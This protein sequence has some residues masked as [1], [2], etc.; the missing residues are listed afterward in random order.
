MVLSCWSTTILEDVASSSGGLKWFQI[1][2]LRRQDVMAKLIKRA[3]SA[4]Y[5]A[6]VLTLDMPVVGKRYKNFRFTFTVPPHPN[7]KEALQSENISMVSPD[8]ENSLHDPS[9]TWDTLIPW[10]KSIT[11]LRV[12]LKG[13]LTIEDA[14]MAV[15]HGVDGI[16]VSNHGGRQLHCVP[17]TVTEF[18]ILITKSHNFSP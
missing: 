9:A 13:I 16:I 14:K 15:K 6:I 12:V 3:E 8:P 17:A 10:V 1:D 2:I 18:P 11:S 4:G 7:L 5:K